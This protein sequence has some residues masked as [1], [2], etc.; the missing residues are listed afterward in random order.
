MA[1]DDA[2]QP[3]SSE[4]DAQANSTESWGPSGSI[5]SR[6]ELIARARSFLNSPQI[7]YQ[8]DTSKRAF[9]MEKGLTET[10]TA[11]LMRER[12]CIASKLY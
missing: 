9:L 10:E 11:N 7:H 8:D 4:T 5:D 1:D 3:T 2:E 12:V 6:N